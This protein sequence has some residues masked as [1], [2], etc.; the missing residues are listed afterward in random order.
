MMLSAWNIPARGYG[1][2]V[3]IAVLIATGLT[4]SGWASGQLNGG[5]PDPARKHHQRSNCHGVYD[6]LV[7]RTLAGG[8]LSSA[9]ADFADAYEAN[10]EAGRPCPVPPDALILQAAN[11]DIVTEAAFYQLTRY[12]QQS[13]PAAH[14]E[15]ALAAMSG[16]VP[17]VQPSLGLATLQEG[18]TAGRTFGQFPDGHLADAAERVRPERRCQGD[19]PSSGCRRDRTCRCTVPAGAGP[20]RRHR[21]AQEPGQ[22][23]GISQAG[24][25]TRPCPRDLFRLPI[26]STAGRG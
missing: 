24:G 11:R 15:L 17:D 26:W 2:L 25:G 9:E 18:R 16:R 19:R 6:V 7:A 22:G 1:L 23:A 20:C 4:G 5:F 3:M 12:V 10:A 21:H 14:Y 13:D 8:A